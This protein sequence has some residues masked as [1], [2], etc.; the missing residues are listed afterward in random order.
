MVN[1]ANTKQIK[2]KFYDII[3]YSTGE[4]ANSLVMNSIYGFAMLYYTE[5]LG[6]GYTLA[7]FAIAV[8]TFW[9]AITDPLM[10]FISDNT[11]SRFGRR[12]PYLLLGG[13]LMILC[14]YFIWAVPDSFRADADLLFWYLVFINLLFRTAINIFIVS[15][16][17]LGF[18][19]CTD[20]ND[21]AK[22]Q[23]VKFVFNMVVNLAGPAL[24]WSLFF[25]NSDDG[26][27]ATDIAANYIDMAT[28]FSIVALVF[29][30]MVVFSTRKYM[31]DSRDLGE[32]AKFSFNMF[33]G[34]FRD[35]FSDRFSRIVFLF[36]TIVF[37][38]IVLVSSL[39]IY[40]YV[41]FMEFSA[42]H[43]S[44]V[45]GAT[46]VGFGIGSAIVPMLVKKWDKK[47]VVFVSV[48]W[49][50]ICNLALIL[51]FVTD[52]LSRDMV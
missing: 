16:G 3:A 1:I 9:D 49:G 30:L 4:G 11:R 31:V 41:F 26:T 45:H 44:F 21:R 23:S 39:Q 43:K 47:P 42:G 24:A 35:I 7:G 32:K 48:I 5:A 37:V 25:K 18:E 40:V 22:L 50:V 38:G 29:V 28:A 20:Y 15:Y 33:I 2:T 51:L 52:F 13:A 10:A 34:Y 27:K 14:Y 6:L 8:A 12:H 19:V 36:T 46:M 17:A